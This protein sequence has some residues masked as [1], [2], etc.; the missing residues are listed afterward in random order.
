MSAKSIVHTYIFNPARISITIVL[1][2]LLVFSDSLA[3][4]QTQCDTTP[5]VWTTSSASLQNPIETFAATTATITVNNTNYNFLYVIGGEDCNTGNSSDPYDCSP[6]PPI[7]NLQTQYGYTQLDSHGSL[8]GFTWLPLWSLPNQTQPVGLSRDLCG[9][10]YTSPTTNKTYLYTVGGLVYDPVHQTRGPSTEIHFAQINP[11][12]GSKFGSLE[13]WSTA[14]YSVPVP[15][16]AAGLELQ[17]TVVVN[18][19]LYIIGG[20]TVDPPPVPNGSQLMS[21]VYSAKLD[22]TSG[23]LMTPFTA[24]GVQPSIDLSTGGVYKTCPV[25]DPTTNTIY[26]AGGETHTS[27]AG[28]AAVWYAIS[29]PD[30]SLTDGNGHSTWT[31]TTSLLNNPIKTYPLA[32]QAIVYNSFI[33]SIILMG[34]DT[35]GMGPDTAKVEVGAVPS[36]N[37]SAT[38]LPSLASVLNNATGG[39]V[40]RNAGAT[41][42]N[43]IYSLGGEQTISK[44]GTVTTT[45][46]PAIYCLQLTSSD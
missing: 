21:A 35:Y 9:V 42:G 7:Q 19:Y 4:A 33:N 46:S 22:P 26:V 5:N 8:V 25:A 20:S 3:F 1:T 37:W 18:G 10:T 23:N 31:Q 14:K 36:L 6:T 32:S 16:G 13:S 17:G 24:T 11:N 12:L 40:E 45:D 30:G 28:T 27:P 15:T 41:V 44:S 29:Q 39:T 34:G 43:F 38:I 2:V